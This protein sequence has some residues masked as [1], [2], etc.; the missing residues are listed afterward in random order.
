MKDG[1]GGKEKPF[2]GPEALLYS[3]RGIRNSPNPRRQDFRR[4]AVSV[5]L[6]PCVKDYALVE[7]EAGAGAEEIGL[8][9]VPFKEL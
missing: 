1:T 8:H 5:P 6:S 7:L 4:N 2:S 9:G 3:P